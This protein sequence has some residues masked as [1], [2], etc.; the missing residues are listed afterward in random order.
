MYLYAPA[1]ANDREI[2]VS[3][4]TQRLTGLPVEIYDNGVCVASVSA[5]E[6]RGAELTVPVT[7]LGSGDWSE[8]ELYA[9][10]KTAQGEI[11]E[12]RRRTVIYKSGGVVL[13]SIEMIGP[14]NARATL[15]DSGTNLLTLLELP[16]EVTYL[17]R[18]SDPAEDAVK[19]VEFITAGGS[20][21]IFR[22]RL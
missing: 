13:D 10:V 12:S 5:Q 21:G 1:Q 7:L 15:G 16:A 11:I 17:A 22:G 9:S 8:H 3:V 2:E 14:D 20:G 6:N 4:D 18:F 19:N